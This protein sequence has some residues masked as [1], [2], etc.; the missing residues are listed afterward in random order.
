MNF[1]NKIIFLPIIIFTYLVFL[2]ISDS[3][4]IFEHLSNL[5]LSYFL[6]FIGLFSFG[7][8][9][10]VLR[11]HNFTKSI[12]S[13]IPFRRNVLYYMSGFA[14]LVTPGRIGELIRSPFIK[15]DYG[16][17][18]SKT[19]IIFF[20]ERFYDL[21]WV[22]TIIGVFL[23]F[24]DLPKTLLIFPL[25]LSSIMII[26]IIDNRIL[27]S[28]TNKM[29]SKSILSKII[30]DVS[31]SFEIITKLFRSKFLILGNLFSFGVVM[32]EALSILF[33]LKSLDI[34]LDFFTLATIFHI[35]NFV[36]AASLIPGGIGVFEGGFTGLL[37]LYDVPKE[38]AVSSSILL[39]IIA[40]GL[41][42]IIGIICLRLISKK[43][44]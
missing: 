38:M 44:N 7:V 13:Q 17:P 32:V 24:T 31:E 39:R 4:K 15:R 29:R 6:L 42:S 33:L 11:W 36:A 12:T 23:P 10:R 21:F 19:S 20:V 37:V 8:A 18:I 30:P 5:N 14:L 25:T 1:Y 9:L 3:Q 40:S 16:I 22:V 43:Q 35:A 2:L 41:F 27:I 34:S 28:L 26:L